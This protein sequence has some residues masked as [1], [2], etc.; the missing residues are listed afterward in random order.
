MQFTLG[1]CMNKISQGDIKFF[2]AHA[3][4]GLSSNAY[5]MSMEGKRYLEMKRLTIEGMAVE[6]ALM[7][8]E[9]LHL[10]EV[11]LDKVEQAE[12]AK[13]KKETTLK[14]VE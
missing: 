9:R 14:S 11:T 4:T 3:L 5:L 1:G 6:S 8:I 13:E 12:E 2:A 7:M 10:M